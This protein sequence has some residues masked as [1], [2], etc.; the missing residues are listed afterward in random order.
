MTPW[1]WHAPLQ[2]EAAKLGLDFFSTAFDP[3]AVDFL[4]ELNVPIHKIASFELVDLPLIE[5]M[6]RTSNR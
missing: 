2:A 6:A 4:E 1:E 3:T 5:T